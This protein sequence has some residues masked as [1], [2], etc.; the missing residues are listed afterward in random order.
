ME[1]QA[2]LDRLA[3]FKGGHVN[4]SVLHGSQQRFPIKVSSGVLRRDTR[5]LP[6]GIKH[7]IR[8]DPSNVAILPLF[9]TNSRQD[10]FRK[11]QVQ[12][13]GGLRSRASHKHPVKQNVILE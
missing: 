1:L 3:T 4:S 5:T 2:E 12:V 10:S 7:D 8:S 13:C 11:R 9:S 6:L